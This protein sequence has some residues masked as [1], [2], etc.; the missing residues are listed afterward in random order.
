MSKSKSE[1]VSA[2]V[3]GEVVAEEISETLTA[4]SND[5]ELRQ[6]WSRYHL[7]GHL[8]Q[9]ESIVPG[10]T[11]VADSVRARLKDEPVRFSP[12]VSRAN[13]PV[14]RSQWVQYIAGTAIA[15]SVTMMAVMVAPNFISPEQGGTIEVAAISAPATPQP[16]Q[17]AP[18]LQPNL[19][20]PIDT[21]FAE[22][23]YVTEPGIRWN[24]GKPE[25]EIE[26]NGYLVNQKV[27]TSMS[28]IPPYATVVSYDSEEKK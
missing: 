14:W 1:T 16:T 28:G 24:L 15:A 22:K 17:R 13:K 8:I 23:S 12:A 3:D 20:L 7:I 4:L 9:G 2:M 27:F 26:L 11:S 10:C 5:E 19:L 6:S 25:A 18:I 21:F